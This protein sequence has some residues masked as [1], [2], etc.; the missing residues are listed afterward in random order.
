MTVATAEAYRKAKSMRQQTKSPARPESSPPHSLLF[1]GTPIQPVPP[2][3]RRDDATPGHG[4]ANVPLSRADAGRQAA[5]GLG[6][7]DPNPNVSKY[8]QK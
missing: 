1:I 4:G 8:A 7:P 5:A 3:R 2:R 6:F